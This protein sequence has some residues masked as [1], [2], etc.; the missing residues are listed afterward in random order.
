M[1]D[2][3]AVR[4]LLCL[5]AMASGCGIFKVRGSAD[6]RQ[7]A[8]SGR[9]VILKET[10]YRYDQFQNKYQVGFENPIRVR[11]VRGHAHL[12]ASL[13]WETHPHQGQ[14]C[15]MKM[16]SRDIRPGKLEGVSDMRLNIGGRIIHL[17]NGAYSQERIPKRGRDD[18]WED[19]EFSLTLDECR[20]VLAPRVFGGQLGDMEF[21]TR[22]S[23]WVLGR[24]VLAELK[25]G[26][27]W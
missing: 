7:W 22:D 13:T 1:W 14:S 6:G 2:K 16:Q 4:F 5:A 23:F 26:E 18:Y 20:S 27:P 11:T 12:R 3:K 17:Q 25:R 8:L 10:R 9:E 24:R 15:F 19:L 21:E